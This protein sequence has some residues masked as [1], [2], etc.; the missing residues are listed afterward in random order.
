MPHLSC[1]WRRGSAGGRRARHRDSMISN[2]VRT[3]LELRR[4]LSNLDGRL[5]AAPF[6][7][8]HAHI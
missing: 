7:R 1:C 5:R 3:Q 8:C 4:F 2:R 6:D